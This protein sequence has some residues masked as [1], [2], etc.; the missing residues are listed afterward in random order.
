MFIIS[1]FFCKIFKVWNIWL[2]IVFYSLVNKLDKERN[3]TDGHG[4]YVHGIK[5]G[6][7]EKM[8]VK[9]VLMLKGLNFESFCY[10]W[11]GF[12]HGMSPVLF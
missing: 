5:M 3:L 1:F 12:G 6:Y 10:I 2:V 7:R 4:T 9:C 11:F 8:E